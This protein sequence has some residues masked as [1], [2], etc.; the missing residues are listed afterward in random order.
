MQETYQ[1]GSQKKEAKQL[2]LRELIRI[3]IKQNKNNNKSQLDDELAILVICVLGV[4]LGLNLMD[5]LG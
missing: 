5:I 2:P 3:N 4:L 1:V